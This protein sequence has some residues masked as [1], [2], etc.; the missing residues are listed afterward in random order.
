MSTKKKQNE[1]TED[2]CPDDAA[3]EGERTPGGPMPSSDQSAV[4]EIGRALDVQYD[5]S[6][7]I[8]IDRKIE[9]REEH[10]WEL[11]PAS[12]EDYRKRLE[13]RKE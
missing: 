12:S 3:F 5:D 7:P 11:V 9:E 8:T 6:E 2:V 4:D 10:R 1:W 13:R